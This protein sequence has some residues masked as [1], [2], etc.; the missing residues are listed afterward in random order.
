MRRGTYSIVARD[1]RTGEI[2]VAVQSHWFSVGSVV[3]WARP[4][5]G[6]VATQSIGEPS[7][8]PGALDLMAAGASAGEALERLLAADPRSR[9]RQVAVVDAAG[10]VAVHTGEGC[11]AFA[12]DRTGD[13]FSAQANMMA[14]PEVWPA[15][16][17]A[18]NASSDGA[19]ARRLLAALRAAEAAGGDARGRQSAA[20]VV[21]PA[22]GEPWRLSV[23]LR[24]EDHPEPLDEVERLLDLSDAYRL[25]SEGDNLVGQGR[26]AEAAERYTRAGGLAPGNH[27][28]LFW[29]G[30]SAAQGGDMQ[31]AVARVRRAIEMQPGWGD[32]LDRLE[33]DIAPS[34]AAVRA[35][36]RDSG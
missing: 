2:G 25:A 22:E 31:T 28:L 7:Y 3:P 1:P 11:I 8:G 5:V 32:L 30:L 15:M 17:R 19:L 13:G 20:I 33:P 12:G 24:V 21:A 9:F 10:R 36:L 18:F 14:T 6:A 34:A 27:E 4:G 29:S 23:D 35:A 16:A 26:H